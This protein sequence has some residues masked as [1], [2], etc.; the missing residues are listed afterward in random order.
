MGLRTSILAG[1]VGDPADITPPV[2]AGVDDVDSITSSSVHVVWNAAVDEVTP[3]ASIR[4][5]VWWNQGYNP[6]PATPPKAIVEGGL[7]EYTIEGLSP[8]TEYRILVRAEDQASNRDTNVAFATVTTADDVDAPSFGEGGTGLEAHALPNGT[9]LLVWNM[10]DDDWSAEQQITYSIYRADA[11][12]DQDFNDPLDTTSGKT[13]YI[14]ETPIDGVGYYV[15]R[16]TDEAGNEDENTDEASTT[17]FDTSSPVVGNFNPAQGAAISKYKPVTFT[18]T[19]DTGFRRI[20]VACRQLLDTQTELVHDGVNFLG[21]YAGTS[22]RQQVAGGWQYSVL[23]RSGWT[24][25]PAFTV[26][27]FDTSGNES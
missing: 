10:A 9:V 5:F 14:D 2:F 12:G 23:R 15:V 19:D 20:L 22:S 27:A 4:Y 25:G 7:L 11:S 21:N 24:S 17:P 18:V 13:Y 26:Y 16:A 8:S 6:N 3:E 1:I